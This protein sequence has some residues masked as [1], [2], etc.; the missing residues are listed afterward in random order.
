[1]KSREKYTLVA[2]GFF[3]FGAASVKAQIGIVDSRAK[4]KP[5]LVILGTYHMGTPGNNIVNGKTDD[6]TTPGRQKQMA[7]LIEKLKKFRPTRIAVEIDSEDALKTQGIY[8]KYLSG[9]YQLTKNETNQIGFRLAKALGHKKI[10]C[11][12]WSGFWDDPAINY[13]K[14]ARQ[15]PEQE[16]FMKGVY[17][18]IKKRVDDESAKLLPLSIVDQLI[19]LNQP[20]RME[21]DHQVYFDLMRIGSGKDYPGAGYLSWWYRRNLVIFDNIIRLTDSPTDRVL[22]IYGVGHNKLLNQLAKESGFYR[23]ESPLRYLKSKG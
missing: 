15:D 6:V 20:A 8:D 3:V 9:N 13:E 10:Y 21:T 12:D 23:V 11:I 1:M 4:V 22:V 17:A 5:T 18:G 2:L 14:Y 19:L 7:A 16:A